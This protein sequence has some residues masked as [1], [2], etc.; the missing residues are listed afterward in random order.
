MSVTLTVSSSQARDMSNTSRQRT[1]LV[2]AAGVA[3]IVLLL[4][5]AAGQQAWS[6][7]TQLTARFEQCMDQAPFKQSLK[8]AQ[9][10][11]QLQPED[12]QRHFDQFNEMFET[13]GLPPVWDGHQLVAWTTFHRVSIQVAKACH[14]ELNI[15]RPQRQLRG[16]YAKSVWDP[17]SAVWRESESLPT[18]SPPSN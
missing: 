14:Q 7:Q 16:T 6:R 2:L 3:L 4:A 1:P 18:T 12:L 11:H 5:G 10:E 15:Q 17:D 13:T 9:P 8:T